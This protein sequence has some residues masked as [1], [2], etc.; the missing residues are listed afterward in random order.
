MKRQQISQEIERKMP[1]QLNELEKAAYIMMSI[2]KERIFSPQY[3]FSDKKTRDKIYRNAR[4]KSRINLQNKETL[5]C[6]TACRLYRYVA[7]RNGLDVYYT[8]DSGKITK[9][10][11]SIFEDGEHVTPVVKLKDG[12]FIKVD[13]EWDLE[14]IQTGMRWM[15]FGTKEKNDVQLSQLSQNEIDDIMC[16]IGYIKDKS[17]YTDF[18][19]EQLAEHIKELTTKEKLNIIFNDEKITQIAQKLKGSVEI[20]RFYRRII[21]EFTTK[22]EGGREK[23]D[24]GKNVFCFGSYLRSKCNKKKYTVCVFYRNSEDSED[25]DKKIWM[26]SKKGKKM[27]EISLIELKH[28]LEN[29]RLKIYPGKNVEECKE[30]CDSTKQFPRKANIKTEHSVMEMVI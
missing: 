1:K 28:F 17:D 13:V 30:L 4:K 14:N 6:V 27:I 22:E 24:Y 11:L 9:N 19:L 16:K 26:W 23:N 8:G 18:Y 7:E 29:K 15:K 5:I 2:G 20:Y 10:D 25:N 12:R 21:K 3:Y